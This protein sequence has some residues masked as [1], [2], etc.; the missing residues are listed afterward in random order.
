MQHSIDTG[1]DMSN[2]SRHYVTNGDRP[3]PSTL[4][5]RVDVDPSWWSHRIF[6]S[7]IR[8]PPPRMQLVVFR[9]DPN[10]RSRQTAQ[11][12]QA[13]YGLTLNEQ[14]KAFEKLKKEIYN[15]IPKKLIRRLGK[16]YRQNA[17]RNASG[18]GGQETEKEV[19]EEEEDE[20]CVICLEE[21][22][23]KA[24]VMVTACNH[25]FHEDCI[26][27]WVKSHGQCPVCRSSFYEE[28]HGASSTLTNDL[29]SFVTSGGHLNIISP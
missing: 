2:N 26:V 5:E 18:S 23:A 29:I 11:S 7:A 21:F 27:P 10:L 25:M 22:E 17:A 9:N 1:Y 14:R 20:K 28:K 4:N 16:F 3:H 24:V 19:E 6:T 8:F 13:N 15:P 12:R